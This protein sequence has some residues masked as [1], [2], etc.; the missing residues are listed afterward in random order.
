MSLESGTLESTRWRGRLAS[1]AGE[2]E[3][4]VALQSVCSFLSANAQFFHTFQEEE[5]VAELVMNYGIGLDEGKVLE[6]SYSPA[7]L[8][9]LVDLGIWLRVEAWAGRTE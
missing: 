8:R 5:G 7:L 1:G 6:I 4:A 2:E 3:Y 9:Q